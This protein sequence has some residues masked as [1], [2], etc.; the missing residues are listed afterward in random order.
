[1]SQLLVVVLIKIWYSSTFGAAV[2]FPWLV[3]VSFF[4]FTGMTNV[5]KTPLP[6]FKT[7][8]DPN[9][10]HDLGRHCSKRMPRDMFADCELSPLCLEY[11][12]IVIPL[13]LSELAQDL[14]YNVWFGR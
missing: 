7:N 2:G 14:E 4:A 11:S 6:W 5:G 8:F 3:E 10:I 13:L 9:A 1:M 12:F